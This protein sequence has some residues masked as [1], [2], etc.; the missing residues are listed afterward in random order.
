MTGFSA[1]LGKELREIVRTWRIWVLPGV[2]LLFAVTGPPTARFTREILASALGDQAGSV[3]LPDPTYLDAYLQW[4]KNLGQL[5]LF[6]VIV[7]LG[8]TVAGER[9]LGTAILVLTKP[10][11]RAAFILAK[12]TSAALLVLGSA[13]LGT[14]ITWALTRAFFPEAPPGRLLAATA[15]WMLLAG[16]FVAVMVLASSV[17]EA[18]AGAAGIGFAVFMTL[19]LAGIWAPARYTTAGLLTVPDALIRGTDVNV[20]GP[21]VTTLVATGLIVALA[22]GV[23]R[24]REI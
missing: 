10:V 19:A 17:V 24:R 11:T 7:M 9:R 14:V 2:M 12:V 6:V 23:F 5:V 13:A 22:I 15:C 4:T 20:A 21:V 8:G 16:F 3:T 1:F 18:T